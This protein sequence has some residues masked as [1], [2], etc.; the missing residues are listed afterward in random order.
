MFLVV[1]YYLHSTANSGHYTA[2]LCD[3]ADENWYQYNDSHVGTT[4]EPA[5]TGGANLLFYRRVVGSLRWAGME[6]QWMEHVRASTTAEDND[7]FREVTR[8]MRNLVSIDEGQS[9][10][11]IRT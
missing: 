5:V 4:C 9:G 1:Y 8:K 3:T 10:H 6:K 2:T 7:S 11:K